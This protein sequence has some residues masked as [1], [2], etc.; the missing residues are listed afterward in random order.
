[1]KKVNR[2][3]WHNPPECRHKPGSMHSRRNPLISLWWAILMYIAGSFPHA[4]PAA[5]GFIVWLTQ[6]NPHRHPVRPTCD[7][8][9]HAYPGTDCFFFLSFFVICA[10]WRTYLFKVL[11][12]RSRDAG[13][14][15]SSW[16]VASTLSYRTHLGLLRWQAALTSPSRLVLCSLKWKLQQCVMAISFV[17]KHSLL[18][19]TSAVLPQLISQ[20]RWVA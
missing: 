20:C 13:I 1:M 2:I 4:G 9:L 16:G 18:H 14:D 3:S 5:K 11:S 15:H 6:S 8:H 7:T 12:L 19:E 10:I 17:P